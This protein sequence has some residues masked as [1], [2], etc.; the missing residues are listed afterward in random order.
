MTFQHSH[1]WIYSF[2]M[3]KLKAN[4]VLKHT[5]YGVGDS[6][7]DTKRWATRIRSS[8]LSDKMKWKWENN[9][10]TKTS[11]NV[12][13]NETEIK[14]SDPVWLCEWVSE[15]VCEQQTKINHIHP[16]YTQQKRNKFQAGNKA[17]I[18]LFLILNGRMKKQH[19]YKYIYIYVCANISS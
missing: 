9:K 3:R 4:F 14:Q 2:N 15:W 6:Q 16:I 12:S 13:L 19:T 8:K 5:V 11:P 7:R 1:L 18:C 17:Q 10:P